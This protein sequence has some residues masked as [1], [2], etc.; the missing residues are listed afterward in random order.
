MA[1]ATQ[2][3]TTTR[4][5]KDQKVPVQGRG[6]RSPDTGTQAPPKKSPKSARQNAVPWTADL[7]PQEPIFS[8]SPRLLYC[9]PAQQQNGLQFLPCTRNLSSRDGT[10]HPGIRQH[11]SHISWGLTLAT[12]GGGQLN[13][14]VLHSAWTAGEQSVHPRS[15]WSHFVGSLRGQGDL[16]NC[17]GSKSF[18]FAHKERLSLS[19]W[20]V[21]NQPHT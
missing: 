18:H 17:R 13:S 1:R 11:F 12:S 16:R 4:N 8:D 3:R 7:I 19:I 10:A 21:L 15:L 5:P 20:H 6:A 2:T 14:K 9:F